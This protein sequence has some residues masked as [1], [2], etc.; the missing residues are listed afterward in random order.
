MKRLVLIGWR[1]KGMFPWQEKRR[2]HHLLLQLCV[3]PSSRATFNRTEVSCVNAYGLFCVKRI[4]EALYSPKHMFKLQLMVRFIKWTLLWLHLINNQC[5]FI[6]CISTSLSYTAG[7]NRL[8]AFQ[9]GS[10]G[11]VGISLY[12]C[13]WGWTNLFGLEVFFIFRFCDSLRPFGHTSWTLGHLPFSTPTVRPCFT[14]NH[15]K[16]RYLRPSVCPMAGSNWRWFRLNNSYELCCMHS[17]MAVRWRCCRPCVNQEL[18]HPA[19]KSLTRCWIQRFL[20]QKMG[21][22]PQRKKYPA[23]Q[24]NT[25]TDMLS[26]VITGPMLSYYHTIISVQRCSFVG[27]STHDMSFF[28]WISGSYQILWWGMGCSGTFVEMWTQGGQVLCFHPDQEFRGFKW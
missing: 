25:N 8:K 22:V 18:Q 26:H 1:I 3:R 17:F 11:S 4:A 2:H 6:Q 21:T 14:W 9:V 28:I 7:L 5:T 15:D 16:K 24:E 27:C 19:I 20:R 13:S 23:F 12:I 10:A